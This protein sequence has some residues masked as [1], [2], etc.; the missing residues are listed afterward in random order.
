MITLTL[1]E[2]KLF[3]IL[4]TNKRL[5]TINQ[6]LI[7]YHIDINPIILHIFENFKHIIN[8]K[9]ENIAESNKTKVFNKTG[10]INSCIV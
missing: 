10:F 4:I 1:V 5:N 2:N 8:L 3:L 9:Y 6:K 7:I